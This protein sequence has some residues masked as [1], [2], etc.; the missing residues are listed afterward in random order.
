LAYY[1]EAGALDFAQAA[2]EYSRARALE[3]GAEK[4]LRVYG[5]YAVLMGQTESGLA[6]L[7]R[8][9]MLDPLNPVA[10]DDV[11]S[12]ANGGLA[13]YALGDLQGARASCEPRADFFFCQ[14][15]LALTYKKLGRHA[16]AE[17]MVGKMKAAY[18]DGPAY[19][20][21][22]IYA[23]WGDTHTALQWLD[24]ATRLRDPGLEGVRVD[25]L[26]DPLRD[27]P[28]FMAIEREL[29]FPD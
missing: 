15:C 11:G 17:N 7:H 23:Q 29:N 27:Q 8:A 22:Q 5:Q 20:L 3:P 26:L 19:Q 2:E 18:G 10:Y 6:A 1:F 28:R 24:T 25:F 4:V 13:H 21:A 16:D 14:L 9:V 12:Y